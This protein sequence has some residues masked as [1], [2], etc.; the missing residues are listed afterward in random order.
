[1]T[2]QLEHVLAG[3]GL[4]PREKQRDADVDGVA[5]PVEESRQRGVTR[6]GQLANER[7]GDLGRLRTRDAHDPD[8][9]ASGR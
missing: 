8:A 4:G 3:I 6:D 7:G 1:V 5:R 2:L 9:A